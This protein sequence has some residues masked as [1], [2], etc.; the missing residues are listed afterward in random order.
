MTADWRIELIADCAPLVVVP[1]GDG[2]LS[3]PIDTAGGLDLPG[4][5]AGHDA[6]AVGPVPICT[7]QGKRW[8]ERRGTAIAVRPVDTD[9]RCRLLALDI[10]V[11]GPGHAKGATPE[12]ADLAARRAWDMIADAG[13]TAVMS[14]SPGGRG[15]HLFIILPISIAVEAAV[16]FSRFLADATIAAVPAVAGAVEHRP[17]STHTQPITLPTPARILAECRPDSRAEYAAVDRLLRG[18]A[19]VALAEER[20][21]IAQALAREARRR[22]PVSGEVTSAEVDLLP[23]AGLAGEVVR[24][25]G[26]E[27]HVRCPHCGG[28]VKINE[29]KRVW[30]CFQCAVGAAGDPAAFLLGRH[31]MPDASNADVFRLLRSAKGASHV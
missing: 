25:I 4:L 22:E 8:I 31:L 11:A 29:R 26:A 21:R 5:I 9:L 27:V 3:F 16:W 7:Y 6:G 30:R 12:A 18:H 15:R 14:K 19:Q 13:L 17:T 28:T 20:A 1:Y 24:Q 10:D 23:V 2:K